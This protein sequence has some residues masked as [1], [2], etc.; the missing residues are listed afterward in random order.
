MLTAGEYEEVLQL[1]GNT[2]NEI[3]AE[4]MSQHPQQEEHDDNNMKHSQYSSSIRWSCGF[5]LQQYD[6]VFGALLQR[7]HI[8]DQQDRP[9]AT[10]N[11]TAKS[12]SYIPSKALS[13]SQKRHQQQCPC[14]KRLFAVWQDI[15]MPWCPPG[16]WQWSRTGPESFINLVT[17]L[18]RQC[19]CQSV[20]SFDSICSSSPAVAVV[21]ISQR[22]ERGQRSSRRSILLLPRHD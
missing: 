1:A 7:C 17:S 8:W 12:T 20:H 4:W 6:G 3:V 22:R 15:W 21:H 18:Y 19:G 16:C 13:T 2:L 11:P 5:L 14:A 10:G 9:R